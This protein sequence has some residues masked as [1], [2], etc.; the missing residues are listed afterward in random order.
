MPQLTKYIELYQ[1]ELNKYHS[2]VEN[3]E[4]EMHK[5]LAKGV[6]S[7]KIIQKMTKL[8]KLYNELG[9]KIEKAPKF[10]VLMAK[11]NTPSYVYMKNGKGMMLRDIKN[12]PPMIEW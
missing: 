11:K 7:D 3:Y 6:I 2:Y 9:E 10:N 5:I 4:S 1:K 12:N 8:S